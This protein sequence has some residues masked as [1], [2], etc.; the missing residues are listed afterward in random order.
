MRHGEAAA[1]FY[2]S[3][4]VDARECA[5]YAAGTLWPPDELIQDGPYNHRMDLAR[6]RREG[7]AL[8]EQALFH[9]ARVGSHG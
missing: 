3:L 1:D 9:A 5:Y 6:E 2:L 7:R 8:E 4:V